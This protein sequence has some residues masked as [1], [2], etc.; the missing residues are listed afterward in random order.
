ME[1]FNTDF[2]KSI[3]KSFEDKNVSSN[4]IK[5]YVR[6]LEKLNDNK[7]L[8][9][10]NFLKDIE[11][12]NTLIQKY[13]PNT[14]RNFL[15]TI[16]SILQTDSK[17]KAKKE[18]YNKYYDKLKNSNTEL[19]HQES[20]NVKS[21]TQK[22]NWITWNEVL[23]KHKQLLDDS[24]FTEKKLSKDEYDKL[25]KC[26]ILSLYVYES[27][28]RNLDY[29]IMK[30]VDKYTN[31]DGNFNYLDLKNKEFIFNKYKTSRAMNL[32][33]QKIK[34]SPELM[35]VVKLYMKY[36]PK[37]NTDDYL[38]VDYDGKAL[39]KTNDMTRLLNS[40]FK[41]KK[42]SSSMLRH[43]FITHKYG[44]IVKEQKETANNMA[45]SVDMQRDYVKLDDDV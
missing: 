40:V 7:P 32:G 38:L 16:T 20:K 23:E 29:Q 27:P 3:I 44:D 12:I 43:I 30:V 19:K 8:K 5:L 42:I 17:T 1:E 14:Q 35:N 9:N 31:Q 39:T 13:K 33:Q 26:M 6:N 4:S 34:I 18:L 11:H 21:E 28:R 2:K 24:K 41:P 36:R 37:E 25:L 45:H 10:L 22:E 15:I